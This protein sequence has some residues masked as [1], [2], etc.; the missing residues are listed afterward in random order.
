MAHARTVVGLAALLTGLSCLQVLAAQKPD[1]SGTWVAVSPKDVAGSEETIT[2]DATRLT[3]GHA[4]SGGGHNSRYTLDGSPTRTVIRSHGQEIVTIAR[5]SWD[6]NRLVINE[7]TTYPDGRARK[8]R[9]I[10]SLDAESQLVIEIEEMID[11]KPGR[12]LQMVMKRR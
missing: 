5:A 6:Q 2:Q 11:G 1:F 4:S 7:S 3:R 8:Q 12:K 9:S 10:L